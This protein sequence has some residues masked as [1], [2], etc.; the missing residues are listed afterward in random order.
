MISFWVPTKPFTAIDAMNR[1]SAAT[2]S[3]RSAIAS[4]D[5]DYNGHCVEVW[6]NDYK[7][8][9]IGHYTWNGTCVIARGTLREVLTVAVREF[10][11][12][13]RGAEIR[14]EVP[15]DQIT[16]ALLVF[17]DFP[18]IQPRTPET[19]AAHNATWRTWKHDAVNAVLSSMKWF[20]PVEFEAWGKSETLEE[21]EANKRAGYDQ[22]KLAR[23][24]V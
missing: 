23:Q 11:G 19:I 16:E 2:G 17:A 9:W 4:G 21:F 10:A 6:F 12:M 3:I 22:L 1:M 24:G 8:Y 13:G 5:A 7:G 20:G 15:E 18:A 14:V